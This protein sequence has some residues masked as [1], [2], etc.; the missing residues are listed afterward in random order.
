MAQKQPM[1]IQA[2]MIFASERARIEGWPR[3]YYWSAVW[4]RLD[5]KRSKAPADALSY[6]RNQ[7]NLYRDILRRPD[8]Y[9]ISMRPSGLSDWQWSGLG[10]NVEVRG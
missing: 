5:A 1:T 3:N 7:L 2:A 8:H 9:K 6:S 10:H 4:W